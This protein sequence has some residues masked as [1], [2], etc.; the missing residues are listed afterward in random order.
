MLIMRGPAVNQFCMSGL[1]GTKKV[2][3]KV[4]PRRHG[5]RRNLRGKAIGNVIVHAAW[6][7]VPSIHKSGKAASRK[8]QFAAR[9]CHVKPRLL[10]AAVAGPFALVTRSIQAVS[11]AGESL[12]WQ[13][14]FIAGDALAFY[15]YK[16]FVPI[17][18]CADYGRAPRW[19]M[20]HA[21]GYVTWT[22]PVLLLVGCYRY[23]GRRPL[24]GL[25]GKSG[26]R[27]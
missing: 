8:R 11:A 4:A 15:L 14:P 19:V 1:G 16:T 5:P 9:C 26:P 20:A 2:T 10:S 18:L 3:E 25:D 23:R 21:W 7:C 6:L 22:V 24:R 17:D 13:R 27:V 12:W